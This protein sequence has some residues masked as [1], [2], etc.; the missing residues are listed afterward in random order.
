MGIYKVEGGYV[1]SSHQVWLP[2]CYED[3]RTARWAYQLP[4]EE[5][6]RLQE[7]ANARSGGT[8]GGVITRGEVAKA[9]ARR[10][11]GKRRS[12]ASGGEE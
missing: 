1:I 9:A 7:E 6:Q 5:L 8:W 2:G 3:M 10:R 4:E 11:E 12:G